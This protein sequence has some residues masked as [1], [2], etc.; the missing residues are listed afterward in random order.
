MNLLRP[1]GLVLVLCTTSVWGDS[2]E[3]FAQLEEFRVLD[4][5]GDRL[6]SKAEAAGNAEIVNKF[7]R[8]DRD[9]DGKL[10]FAEFQRL[11]KMKTSAA[12]ATARRAP[13]KAAE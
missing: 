1:A 3:N 9:K 11:K 12:G 6:V 2:A 5:D 4:L 13:R 8:A 10:S 7:D